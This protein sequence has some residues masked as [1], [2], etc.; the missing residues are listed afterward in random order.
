MMCLHGLPKW[1]RA[2]YTTLF[3]IDKLLCFGVMLAKA[4]KTGTILSQEPLFGSFICVTWMEKHERL[5]D[6]GIPRG[7]AL[8]V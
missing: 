3:Q 4:M 8:S 2:E 5:N 1:T 7:T 6:Y